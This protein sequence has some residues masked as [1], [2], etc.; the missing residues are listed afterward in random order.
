MSQKG[1]DG[2]RKLCKTQ[3]MQLFDINILS[4]RIE[5]GLWEIAIY[6]P[7]DILRKKLH[8]DKQQEFDETVKRFDLDIPNF[9]H[10]IDTLKSIYSSLKDKPWVVRAIDELCITYLSSLIVLCRYEAVG[11]ALEKMKEVA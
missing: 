7:L 2:L 9:E 1:R 8:E 4:S 11:I 6:S 10:G 5:L 3:N